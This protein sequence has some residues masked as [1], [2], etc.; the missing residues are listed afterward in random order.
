[1]TDEKEVRDIFVDHAKLGPFRE[2]LCRAIEST[3]TSFDVTMVEAMDTLLYIAGVYAARQAVIFDI[4][5]PPSSVPEWA[6]SVAEAY[7]REKRRI[8]RQA[9]AGNA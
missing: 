8:Q 6:S 1:M 9:G 2:A 7:H 4:P 5:A 3:A